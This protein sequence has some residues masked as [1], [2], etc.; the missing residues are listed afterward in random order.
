MGQTPLSP[1]TS[2]TA[3]LIPTPTCIVMI[4]VDHALPELVWVGVVLRR[5]L[6]LFLPQEVFQLFLVLLVQ[7]FDLGLQ[8]LKIASNENAA[9]LTPR[10]RLDNV[11]HSRQLFVLLFC[12]AARVQFL[13]P[14]GDLA[15]IVLLNLVQVGRVEP[16]VRKEG[17]V[18][19][20]FL[21][22][23]LQVHAEGVFASNVVH[24]Q[25]VVDSLAGTQRGKQVR[26]DA[27]VLPADVPRQ[28]FGI[29]T[30]KFVHFGLKVL[31]HRVAII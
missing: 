14:F 4:V 11:Q 26:H 10:L 6:L 22:K 18:L 3:I 27:K 28:L 15:R 16:S 23:A 1:S 30:G 19:G 31:A 24:A 2:S 12:H 7:G 29:L 8:L 17:V 20:E 13:F 9:P 21:L 5:V 25:E